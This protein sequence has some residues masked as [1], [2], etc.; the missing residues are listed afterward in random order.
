MQL[1]AP[2]ISWIWGHF[3]GEGK[4]K[5]GKRERKGEGKRIGERREPFSAWLP[6]HNSQDPRSAAVCSTDA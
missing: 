3:V 4:E 5:G 6:S 1:N 2:K